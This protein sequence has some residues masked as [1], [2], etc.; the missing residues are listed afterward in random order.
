M[1][2][3]C[4]LNV[5]RSQEVFPKSL[6]AQVLISKFFGEENLVVSYTIMGHPIFG[7]IAASGVNCCALVIVSVLHSFTYFSLLGVCVALWSQSGVVSEGTL[8]VMP[9]NDSEGPSDARNL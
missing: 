2:V 6:F 9:S 1:H 7:N 8:T 3:L 5:K 4:T